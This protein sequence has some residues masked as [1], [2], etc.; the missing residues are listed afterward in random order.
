MNKN[1]S[2]PHQ[3]DVEACLYLYPPVSMEVT[4]G[5][6]T[7][8][9]AG[10]IPGRAPIVTGAHF[11]AGQ[12]LPAPAVPPGITMRSHAPR[13]ET[14]D[15]RRDPPPVRRAVTSGRLCRELGS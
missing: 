3:L 7:V 10:Q 4:C 9:E 14:L 1:G 8:I 2:D 6:M 11:G 15:G 12:L 13:P 5:Q